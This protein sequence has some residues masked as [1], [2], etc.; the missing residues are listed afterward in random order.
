MAAS[1]KLPA[2]EQVFAVR[3]WLG[4]PNDPQQQ[5]GT[6]PGG[7]YPI[8]LY[9]LQTATTGLPTGSNR[10]YV[11][12][13]GYH[14]RRRPDRQLYGHFGCVEEQEAPKFW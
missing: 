5:H 8:R 12:C 4:G 13:N 11:L 2:T 10:L 6:H 7:P 14:H 9:R 1:P 3:T